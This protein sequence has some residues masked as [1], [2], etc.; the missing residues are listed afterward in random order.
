MSEASEK[1]LTATQA[2]ILKDLQS[3]D[4]KKVFSALEK[5]AENG[6][7]HSIYPLLELFRDTS[8]EEIR[9][10]VRGLLESLKISA[11]EELLVQ[12]L[13]DPEFANMRGDLLSFMWNSGIQPVDAIDLIVRVSL[14]NDFMTGVEGMTLIES[15]NEA[16]EEESLYQALVYTREFLKAHKDDDH[17]LFN[18]AVSLYELLSRFEM[19]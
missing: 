16:P 10:R 4:D 2:K 1:K 3:K 15:L 17:E 5:T 12:A 6:G 7:E 18:V 13:D 14:E 9:S 19:E 8:N 11:A